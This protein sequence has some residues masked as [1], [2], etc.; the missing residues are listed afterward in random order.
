LID[1][2]YPDF[3]TA[4]GGRAIPARMTI[5]GGIA[6]RLNLRPAPPKPPTKEHP[7]DFSEVE[8][9]ISEM[10]AM[11]AQLTKLAGKAQEGKHLLA[12]QMTKEDQELLRDIRH[13]TASRSMRGVAGGLRRLE[14]SFEPPGDEPSDPTAGLNFNELQLRARAMRTVG[15]PPCIDVHRDLEC[16]CMKK[17]RM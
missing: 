2:Y 3:F 16:R 11:L 6:L 14:T 8:K 10:A 15:V 13:D 1:C 9:T 7:T 4:N 5:F 12:A 17:I